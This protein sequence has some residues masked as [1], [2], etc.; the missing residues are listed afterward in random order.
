MAARSGASLELSR[1]SL[2]GILALQEA[3][4]EAGL[5]DLAGVP[6]IGGTTVGGMDKRN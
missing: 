1:T 5:K 3:L 6:L 4:S 2:M